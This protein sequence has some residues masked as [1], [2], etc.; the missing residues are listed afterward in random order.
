[1]EVRKIALQNFSEK[2]IPPGT[3]LATLEEVLVP[4]YLF[5]RYQLEAAAKVVGG[6]DYTFAVRGD[7]R[8]P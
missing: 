2:K 4:M 8:S 1:M 7:G 3:P 5:H 6:V